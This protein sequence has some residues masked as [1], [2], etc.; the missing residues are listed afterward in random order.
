MRGSLCTILM[1]GMV[2]ALMVSSHHAAAAADLPYQE[3]VIMNKTEKTG[4]DRD[5]HDC[6]HSAGYRWCVRTKQCER[7]WELARNKGFENTRE[8]FDDY[9]GNEQ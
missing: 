2:L 4:A 5:E 8:A 9:C 7:P 6:I 1:S 3:K